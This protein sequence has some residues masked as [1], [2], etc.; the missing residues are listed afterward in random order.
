MH[1]KHLLSCL[2]YPVSQTFKHFELS[3]KRKGDWQREQS[4]EEVHVKQV[5]KQFLQTKEIESLY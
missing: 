3:Y 4:E 5:V 2:K 1:G